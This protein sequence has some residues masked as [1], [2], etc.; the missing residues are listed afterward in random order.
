MMYIYVWWNPGLQNFIKYLSQINSNIISKNRHVRIWMCTSLEIS[1]WI[2]S[3]YNICIKYKSNICILP[4]IFRFIYLIRQIN[5]T[6]S[7]LYSSGHIPK[8]ILCDHLY[9]TEDPIKG[10]KGNVAVG[11]TNKKAWV[12]WVR[13]AGSRILGADYT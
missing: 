12:V 13:Q 5:S 2:T 4:Y 10:A 8:V 3:S 11:G 7:S 6:Q 9:K 1:R